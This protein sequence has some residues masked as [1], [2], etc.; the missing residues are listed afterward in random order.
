MANVCIVQDKTLMI[1]TFIFC[2][3]SDLHTFYI[4]LNFFFEKKNVMLDID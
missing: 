2:S 3:S 1:Y 4:Y